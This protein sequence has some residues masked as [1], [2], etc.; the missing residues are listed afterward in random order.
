M[1]TWTRGLQ[2]CCAYGAHSVRHLGSGAAV[3]RMPH[4]DVKSLY[5]RVTVYGGDDFILLSRPGYLTLQRQGG[6][7]MRRSS[8]R[9]FFLQDRFGV[10]RDLDHVADDDA[11]S[12]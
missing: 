4:T 3:S 12:V 2:D 7:A 9:S 6:E 1:K 5:V 8:A 11:T 10:D